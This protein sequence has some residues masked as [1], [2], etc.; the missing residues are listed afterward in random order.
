MAELELIQLDPSKAHWL[1][2]APAIKVPAN[3]EY[4]FLSG[5]TAIPLYHMQPH[6]E[7]E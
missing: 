5:A 1:P 7:E 2:Y 3:S 6:I 4:F